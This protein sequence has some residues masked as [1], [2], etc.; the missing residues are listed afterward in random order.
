MEQ[1]IGYQ[2]EFLNQTIVDGIHKGITISTTEYFV[3]TFNIIKFWRLF[4]YNRF[5][6]KIDNKS[7]LEHSGVN[8]INVKCTIFLY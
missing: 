7:W 1:F 5:R 2:D 3:N 4:Y 8:F 6:E